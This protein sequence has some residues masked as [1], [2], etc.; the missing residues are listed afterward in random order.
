IL[1]VDL[2]FFFFSSR[3]RHTRSKRD[4][5]SDVCSSDLKHQIHRIHHPVGHLPYPLF[6]ERLI[7]H[8]NISSKRISVGFP[9]SDQCYLYHFFI[10][11]PIPQ[12][13]R[14]T[15]SAFP[16]SSVQILP[17]FALHSRS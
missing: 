15:S 16:A 14:C 17:A 7:R 4:W 12:T 10:T 8:T 1:F 13:T 9:M 5:S 2:V 11:I 6:T 3:R